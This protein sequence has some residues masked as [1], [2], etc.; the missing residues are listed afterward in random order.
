M[1]TNIYADSGEEGVTMR[2]RIVALPG[3]AHIN[4]QLLRYDCEN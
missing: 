2:F 4:G 3:G 1:M